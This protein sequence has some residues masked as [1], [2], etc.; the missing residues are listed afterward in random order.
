LLV[1]CVIESVVFYSFVTGFFSKTETFTSFVPLISS[2]VPLIMFLITG[3]TT[4]SNTVVVILCVFLPY[5]AMFQMLF[6]MQRAAL[7]GEG[8]D[9]SAFQESD[10]LVAIFGAIANIIIFAALNLIVN[11]II[12]K[13]KRVSDESVEDDET[14]MMD[15]TSR[16]MDM[17]RALLDSS[18]NLGTMQS[19]DTSLNVFDPASVI[20]VRDAVERQYLAD[21]SPSSSAILSA[22]PRVSGTTSGSTSSSPLMN[23]SSEETYDSYSSLDPSIKYALYSHKACK[24]YTKDSEWAVHKVSIGIEK[25]KITVLLGANG[26]GK[27]TLIRLLSHSL[28]PTRGV[29][30][31]RG[32]IGV[33]PQFD[34]HLLED[35]TVYEHIKFYAK[36]TG[37]FADPEEAFAHTATVLSLDE[38][39]NTPSKDLSGGYKRRL[40]VAVALCMRPDVLCLDEISTGVDPAARRVLWEALKEMKKDVAI[41]L[42]THSMEEAESLG[43]S[44][45][46]M[47]H[48]HVHVSGDVPQLTQKFSENFCLSLRAKLGNEDV[49][50]EDEA[51]EAEERGVIDGVTNKQC[52]SALR[53]MK[54]LEEKGVT[55]ISVKKLFLTTDHFVM[56]LNVNKEGS[57]L[58][59][60]L[61]ITNQLKES[62]YLED[63]T[64]QLPSLA[65]VFSQIASNY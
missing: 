62:N 56:E 21:G 15:R 8:L 5:G 49:F 57:S 23:S 39:R 42:S 3:F 60:L 30:V 29:I 35:L 25:G 32:K 50:T 38:Y 1:L 54:L 51:R 63:C 55:D 14:E 13:M 37:S 64:I 19:R 65:Q 46:I 4:P 48:S 41:L 47:A 53:F 24:K 61:R 17:G 59:K 12:E 6:E 31:R 58:S 44:I 43:D 34:N 26:A 16:S 10:V 28:K 36:I 9:L 11:L 18:E 27:T 22:L 45:V 33:A 2:I 7:S 52:I 40:T 20:E